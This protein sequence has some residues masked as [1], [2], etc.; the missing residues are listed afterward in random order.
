MRLARVMKFWLK[1]AEV[2]HY[3]G[4]ENKGAV[5]FSH[6][7]AY[8]WFQAE[9]FAEL[10]EM[11]LGRKP[12]VRDKTTVFKSLG[13]AIEDSVSAKLVLDLLSSKKS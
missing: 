3:P 7:M 2:L 4:S 12:V 10:G 9:I 13:L 11:I 5:P 1:Q 6:E 8:L